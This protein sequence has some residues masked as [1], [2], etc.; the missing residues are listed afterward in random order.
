MAFFKKVGLEAKILE[1]KAAGFKHEGPMKDAL[2]VNKA[3]RHE[4]KELRSALKTVLEKGKGK[5][6]SL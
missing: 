3:E 5:T 4:I 2:S 6:L 1:S